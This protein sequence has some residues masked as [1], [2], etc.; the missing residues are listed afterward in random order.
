MIRTGVFHYDTTK[1]KLEEELAGIE[2]SMTT[3]LTQATPQERERHEE[4]LRTTR[5]NILKG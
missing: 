5:E 1:K 4:L 2:G 3:A